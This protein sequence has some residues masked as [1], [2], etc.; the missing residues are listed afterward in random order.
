LK[1]ILCRTVFAK[2][3]FYVEFS[4]AKFKRGNCP[5][6]QLFQKGG[7]FGEAKTQEGI[8]CHSC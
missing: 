5:K 3:A 1:L 8:G 6:W 4:K 2:N 7:N